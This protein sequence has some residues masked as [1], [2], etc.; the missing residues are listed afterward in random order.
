MTI[1]KVHTAD[2]LKT[3]RTSRLGALYMTA[4]STSRKD[5]E[6]MGQLELI[7]EEIRHRPFK[8]RAHVLT[9]I[10]SALSSEISRENY[11]QAALLRDMQTHYRSSVLD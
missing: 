9:Q 1:V 7:T 3:W 11:E 10:D 4:F 2:Q 6:D 8:Q 5:A